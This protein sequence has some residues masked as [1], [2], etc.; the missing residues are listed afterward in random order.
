MIK[1]I[2]IWAPVRTGRTWLAKRIISELN[3]TGSVYVVDEFFPADDFKPNPDTLMFCMG[4][5]EITPAEEFKE[6]PDYGSLKMV[7]D[8]CEQSKQIRA[9]TEEFGLK[10]FDVSH[11]R[12]EQSISKILD[13]VKTQLQQ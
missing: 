1:N 8:W 2:V 12:G 6:R 4:Y 9:I 3:F 7:E 11:A 5:S 10:Y 13:Y